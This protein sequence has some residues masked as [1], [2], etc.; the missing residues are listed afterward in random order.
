MSEN[1][2]LL[3]SSGEETDLETVDKPRVKRLKSDNV[4][5]G[6]K[7]APLFNVAPENN[8]NA[9]TCIICMEQLVENGPHRAVC[10]KCGHIFGRSCILLWLKEKKRCPQCNSKSKKSDVINLFNLS[11][12]QAAGDGALV[13]ELEVQLQKEKLAR[14]HAE[15]ETK[16]L[17]QQLELLRRQNIPPSLPQV[18]STELSAS[19]LEGKQG[20]EGV[21][22]SDPCPL[23]HATVTNNPYLGLP[24]PFCTTKQPPA[25]YAVHI[26][27]FYH[28]QQRPVENICNTLNITSLQ[29]GPLSAPPTFSQPQR[30]Y[31][32][33]P[34]SGRNTQPQG[35]SAYMPSRSSYHQGGHGNMPVSLSHLPLECSSWSTTLGRQGGT[36]TQLPPGAYRVMPEQHS[37]QTY[38]NTPVE[39][40]QNSYSSILPC[41]SSGH[42]MCSDGKGGRDWKGMP[43]YESHNQLGRPSIQPIDSCIEGMNGEVVHSG[44]LGPYQNV[45]AQS[46][47]AQSSCGRPGRGHTPQ[48]DT[49]AVFESVQEYSTCGTRCFAMHVPSALLLIP[50]QESLRP[51]QRI[52]GM[53]GSSRWWLRKASILCPEAPG[54]I[55]LPDSTGAVRDVKYNAKQQLVAVATQGAGLLVLSSRSDSIVATFNLGS[56]AWSCCWG[57][58]DSH[59]LYAGLKDGKLMRINMRHASGTSGAS[60]AVQGAS[61]AV[62]V[63]DLGRVGSR[64]DSCHMPLHTVVSLRSGSQR[65]AEGHVQ[66]PPAEAH[67]GSLGD[68]FEC[69]VAS[70]GRGVWGL[71]PQA[72]DPALVCPSLEESA[73]SQRF[74]SLCAP[75]GHMYTCESVACENVSSTVAV[76]W[77]P[78]ALSATPPGQ[79]NG[80]S[81]QF[82]AIHKVIQRMHKDE[83]HEKY[84]STQQL[85]GLN[86]N[87]SGGAPLLPGGGTQSAA[88]SSI[89]S[90][91]GGGPEAPSGIVS[92]STGAVQRAGEK[93]ASLYQIR[94]IQLRAL[95]DRNGILFYAPRSVSPPLLPSPL[96]AMTDKTIYI[97]FMC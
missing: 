71:K 78:P 88:S 62:G 57:A 72:S 96:A 4:Q 34:S 97:I 3:D 77:R 36:S 83:P 17:Q 40:I 37:A 66:R 30:V 14:Q 79:Q 63:E 91:A 22:C 39:S 5:D 80:L 26:P 46:R 44:V 10:L 90:I 48:T 25:G 86:E 59:T 7:D 42:S 52:E 49:P 50:L 93:W 53:S 43:G 28:H 31:S 11:K 76:S 23:L 35:H 19:K 29:G 75:P 82:K 15:Q 73:R 94:R 20:C 24:Q 81:C 61:A 70:S 12:V 55:R 47:A 13:D 8:E 2:I 89:S 45:T 69:L 84:D 27:H 87:G 67:E 41:L 85:D 60:A 56:P 74:V 92:P 9:S 65:E 64:V 1:V 6:S 33:P 32:N 54:R 51:Q 58:A 38:R 16:H 18:P 68:E 21:R 95:P